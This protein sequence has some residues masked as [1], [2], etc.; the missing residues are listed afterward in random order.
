MEN[1]IQFRKEGIYCVPGDFYL[2][3]WLPVDYAIISHG[4]ADHARWGMK[5]YLC[6]HFTKPII[7]HRIGADISVESMA[8]GE[9][10]TIRN[11]QVSLHP[12]GHLIGSSQI[13]LEYKG[14]IVVFTGDFKVDK[15]DLSTPYE[16]VP[17]DIFITEST[18]GL[19]IYKWKS[20]EALSHELKE[21]VTD[22]QAK[23]KTSVFIGYSL[24]KA[25]RI[26]KLIEGSGKIFVHSSIEKLNQAISSTGID[27]PEYE[28]MNIDSKKDL[29]QQIVIVPPALIGSHIIKK[30]P[31]ASTAM[32][33]G[34]MQVRGKRRWK[35]V[36]AGFVVSDHADWDGL[37]SAVKACS[38][39][40]TYVTHGSQAIFSKYLN[41]IGYPAQELIT[42]YGEENEDEPIN[43]D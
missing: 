31:N 12:A 24:G 21:W 25:Q 37:I 22:N 2:D 30:I 4:H 43:K 13:R 35:A 34:W 8:Y 7:Q 26:M 28:L 18:F 39:E 38:P 32:C 42:Q 5:H 3:P 40:M 33:S 29:D 14:R 16:P 20:N 1:F 17:C 41:E 36:D 15:D 19:P 27:L 11:V 23:G 10:K 9:N 6:H